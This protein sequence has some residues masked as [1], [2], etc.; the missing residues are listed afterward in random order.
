[1]RLGERS[2]PIRDRFQLRVTRLLLLLPLLRLLV[3][4]LNVFARLCR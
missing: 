2:C 4:H 3:A 1:M